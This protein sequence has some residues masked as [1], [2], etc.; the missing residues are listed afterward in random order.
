MTTRRV[1]HLCLLGAMA[2]L[3]LAYACE[4]MLRGK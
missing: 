3:A 4:P 1:A 2:I